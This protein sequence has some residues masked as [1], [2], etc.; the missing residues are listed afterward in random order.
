[1]ERACV[2]GLAVL[3]CWRSRVFVS[4]EI[5]VEKHVV[6]DPGRPKQVQAASRKDKLVELDI[7][8]LGITM[9]LP[10]D[11]AGKGQLNVS[12]GILLLGSYAGKLSSDGVIVIGRGALLRGSARA[13]TLY[14]D[15]SVDRPNGGGRSV[16]TANEVVITDAAVVVADIRCHTFTCGKGSRVDGT[17]RSELAL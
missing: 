11:S 1:M 5:R 15:G 4:R 13:R 7:V 12:G 14:I 8:E 10:R 2:L 3:G 9:V 17:I 16:I 6:V